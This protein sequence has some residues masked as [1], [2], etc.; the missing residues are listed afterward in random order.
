[1]NSFTA[2]STVTGWS[3]ISV[4][5]MPT[6]RFDLISLHRVLDIAPEREHIA[7]LAHGDG[8]PDAVLSVDAEHGLS[9][10]GRAACDTGDVAQTNH[11]AV[12]DE[13]DRQDVLLGPE[14]ARDADED[15]FVVGLEHALR[16]DGV[17][18]REGGDQRGPVDPEARE[19]LGRE[20][21]V[22]TLVLRPKHVDL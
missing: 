14:R 1:M 12:R 10:V 17:L 16:R 9:R 6:G 13:I 20:L 2:S 4:G 19:L 3:A 8:E 21:H 15:F 11:P 18:G 5:S 22:D 7:A